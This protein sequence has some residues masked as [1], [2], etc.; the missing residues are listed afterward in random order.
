MLRCIMA[1]PHSMV[2]EAT[3]DGGESGIRTHDSI[4]ME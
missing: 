3:A 2:V 1:S 4:Y